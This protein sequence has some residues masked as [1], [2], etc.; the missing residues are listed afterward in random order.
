MWE[1]V[2]ESNDP[3][4]SDLGAQ[5]CLALAFGLL[6][7]LVF[8]AKAP[9]GRFFFR[10]MGGT[11]VVSLLAAFLLPTLAGGVAWSDAS[12]LL[13]LLA[14]LAFPLYARS[15]HSVGFRAGMGLSLVLVGAALALTLR[16][17][18]GL[19]LFPDLGLA[20]L[21]A[22]AGGM[23]AGSVGLAMVLGHWYLT[24]PKLAVEHLE[25]ANRLSILSMLVSL[26]CLGLTCLVFLE[27]FQSA[28]TPLF[29]AWGLLQLATRVAFG[30]ALPL[31]FAWMTAS[32]LRHR[33][34]RS[35][36]GILYASTVLVLIGSALSLSL[37]NSYGVPL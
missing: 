12:I 36:T 24:V 3:V 33:N 14:V 23:V 19:A 35:A 4:W 26:G 13:T 21:T 30:I 5:Y 7:A 8:V 32:S 28:R 1:R 6:L 18:L 10:L 15:G 20:S 16:R 9:L 31:L 29:G 25:R 17:A 27:R 11:A 37:Q 34:T 22:L 2:S